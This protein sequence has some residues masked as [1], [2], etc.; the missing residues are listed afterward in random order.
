V[1]IYACAAVDPVTASVS[2]DRPREEVFA[3]LVDIA[4]H[5]EFTDHYLKQFRLTRLDSVGHGAGARFKVDQPFGRFS[6]TDMTF[7]E[8]EPPHRI[9]ALGR[10]GKF[11]RIK[12][13][14]IW[15]LNRSPGGGTDLDFMVETEPVLPTDKFVE[16]FSG[17]RGWFKRKVSKSLSR[18]QSILEENEDRGARATVAGV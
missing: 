2:I 9:V 12:T 15:T 13:T 5:A 1:S 14:T 16:A 10:G 3:Y 18:L 7:V 4:N 17:Q 6:W 8:V 11:N